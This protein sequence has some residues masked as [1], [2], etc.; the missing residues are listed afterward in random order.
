MIG[1]MFVWKRMWGSAP[2][3]PKL[4]DYVDRLLERSAGMSD[5]YLV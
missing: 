4:E 1:S 2:G 3:R 5:S